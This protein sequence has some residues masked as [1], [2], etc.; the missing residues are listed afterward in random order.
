MS[1]EKLPMIVIDAAHT[2]VGR[3]ASHAAKQALLGKTVAV[4]NCEKA[5]VTGG[6][7]NILSRYKEM[8]AKG[9][10]SQRGPYFPTKPAAIVKRTIRGMLSHK[11]GRG[12]AAFDRVRCY[13][14]VPQSLANTTA[15][16]HAA[17]E[18]TKALSMAEISKELR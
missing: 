5:I 4:I 9:G 1:A 15:I 17:G 3:L 14:G 10:S 7:A 12:H 11:E 18:H 8:R 16:S 6:K 2:A 13:E